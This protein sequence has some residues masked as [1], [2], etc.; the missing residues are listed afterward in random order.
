MIM[1][2]RAGDFAS[3]Q[4][5]PSAT[6]YVPPGWAHRTVNTADTPLVFLATYPGDA[7]HDYESIERRGFSRRVHRG[8]GGH[9][10]RPAATADSETRACR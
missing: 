5:V 9:E 1:E 10:L 6:V 7:G 3:A 4:L 2:T 8:D